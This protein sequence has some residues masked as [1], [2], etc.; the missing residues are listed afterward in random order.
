MNDNWFEDGSEAAKNIMM[1]VDIGELTGKSYNLSHKMARESQQ[2]ICDYDAI[3]FGK[4]FKDTLDFAKHGN[5]IEL[6]LRLHA[7]L[8]ENLHLYISSSI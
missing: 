8:P 4:A 5:K 3:A 6:R 7:R 2:G 1:Y